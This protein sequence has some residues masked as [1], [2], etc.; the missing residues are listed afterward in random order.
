VISV[1]LKDA[2]VEKVRAQVAPIIAGWVGLGY[3]LPEE[4]LIPHTRI[5]LKASVLGEC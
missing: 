5:E 4:V 2:G 1:D 3:W